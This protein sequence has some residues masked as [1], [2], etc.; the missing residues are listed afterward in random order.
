MSITLAVHSQTHPTVTLKDIEECQEKVSTLKNQ[1]I[2]NIKN[3]KIL[4]ATAMTLAGTAMALGL[5]LLIT[6]LIV[7]AISFPLVMVGAVA[8]IA[9]TIATVSTLPT[10]A[11][12]HHYDKKIV[13][14][15]ELIDLKNVIY[16]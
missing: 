9:L 11:A 8:L 15:S 4:F 16:L 7:P 5:G 1:N 14:S 3:S 10:L 6:T 2:K 13:N 12:M